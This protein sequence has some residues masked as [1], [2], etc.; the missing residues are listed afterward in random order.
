MPNKYKEYRNNLLRRFFPTY[1]FLF[2]LVF[3]IVFILSPLSTNYVFKDRLLYF[4]SSLIQSNA[5]IIVLFALTIVSLKSKYDGED[6]ESGIPHIIHSIEIKGKMLHNIKRYISIHGIKEFLTPEYTPEKNKKLEVQYIAGLFYYNTLLFTLI[7]FISILGILLDID[8]I[9]SQLPYHFY[10]NSYALPCQILI[11]SIVLISIISIEAC[12]LIYLFHISERIYRLYIPHISLIN[13]VYRIKS[14]EVIF[15]GL[16]EDNCKNFFDKL[17]ATGIFPEGGAFDI[18][19]NA[20]R[21]KKGITEANK[22]YSNLIVTNNADLSLKIIGS[23][24]YEF[25]VMTIKRDFPL[26]TILIPLFQNGVG[27]EAYWESVSYAKYLCQKINVDPIFLFV[28]IKEKDSDHLE[29]DFNKYFDNK[30]ETIKKEYNDKSDTNLIDIINDA[31]K[32]KSC[33]LIII[34]KID[35]FDTILKES[36]HSVLVVQ[37]TRTFYRK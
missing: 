28:N 9:F 26:N 35:F 25:P 30:I 31:G 22:E 4:F 5:A 11:K 37:G 24:S 17:G 6:K 8:K 10:I 12:A 29:K 20:S 18:Q 15:S 14:E 16:L 21:I 36:E 19:S 32:E 3:L 27:L 1:M 33:D 2:S 34:P 7:I 23:G 13:R